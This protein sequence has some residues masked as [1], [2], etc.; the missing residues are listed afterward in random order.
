[1]AKPSLVSVN[2]YHTEESVHEN[3]FYIL[4]Y[5]FQISLYTRFQLSEWNSINSFP[6]KY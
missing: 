5:N 4:I 1:M 2:F 6:F 3:E